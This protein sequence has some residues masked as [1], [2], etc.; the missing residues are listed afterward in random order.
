MVLQNLIIEILTEV[1]ETRNSDN[2]LYIETVDRIGNL[3]GI[4]NFSRRAVKNILTMPEIPSYESISRCRRKI[5]EKMPELQADEEV[6]KER[7]QRE[8]SWREWSKNPT[9]ISFFVR[10]TS[11][12]SDVG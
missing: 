1:P 2:L 5:Q 7:R 11:D 9:P 3:M 12:T 6:L 8:I 10:D 4:K